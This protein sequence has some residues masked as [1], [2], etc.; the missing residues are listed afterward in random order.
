MFTPEEAKGHGLRDDQGWRG[1]GTV[2]QMVACPFTSTPS[3]NLVNALAPSLEGS[4]QAQ[5]GALTLEG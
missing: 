3:Q 2:F 4:P 5:A 1:K